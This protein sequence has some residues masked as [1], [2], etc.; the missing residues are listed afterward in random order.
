MTTDPVS[1]PVP[2][3]V[4]GETPAPRESDLV[5]MVNVGRTDGQRRCDWRTAAV[6]ARSAV[7][8]VWIGDIDKEGSSAD[9]C[10]V[11]AEVKCIHHVPPAHAQPEEGA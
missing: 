5:L 7:V 1:E 4:P 3:T 6:C 10:P 2:V 11:H 8:E 9:Y